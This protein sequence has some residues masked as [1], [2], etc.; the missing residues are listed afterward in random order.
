MTEQT[1]R[2]CGAQLKPE[3]VTRLQ[4]YENRWVLVENVPA[5]VCA[6]CGEV[7]Y[8][9]QAHDLVLDLISGNAPGRIEEITVYNADDVA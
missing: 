1:C 6:Q 9:P 8:T 4:R 3:R 7:Y 5:L 2:F